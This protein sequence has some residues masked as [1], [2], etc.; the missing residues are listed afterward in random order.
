MLLLTKSLTLISL[1]QSPSI[2]ADR[3][4]LKHQFSTEYGIQREVSMSEE[5]KNI[6]IYYDNTFIEIY[7]NDGKDTMTLRAF[8]ENVEINLI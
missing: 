5:L 3:S 6:E 7:L 1:L 2:V 4:T 8:P